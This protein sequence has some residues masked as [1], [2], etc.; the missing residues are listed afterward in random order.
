MYFDN[1]AFLSMIL[2]YSMY[3]SYTY[4]RLPTSVEAAAEPDMYWYL[5][6]F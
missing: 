5:S 1:K 2:V 3:Y 4:N 6:Y